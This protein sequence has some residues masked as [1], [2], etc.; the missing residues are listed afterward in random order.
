MGGGGG[1]WSDRLIVVFIMD[2]AGDGLPD[3]VV[4]GW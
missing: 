3:A 1:W 4:Y 2:R